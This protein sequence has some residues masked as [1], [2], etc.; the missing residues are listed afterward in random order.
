MEMETGTTEVT[1]AM[2]L[3]RAGQSVTVGGHWWTVMYW[4]DKTVEVETVG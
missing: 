3:L 4:V 1:V 2:L